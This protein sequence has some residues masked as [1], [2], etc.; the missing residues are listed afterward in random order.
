MMIANDLQ[1][2]LGTDGAAQ[3]CGGAEATQP[4]PGPSIPLTLATPAE[5]VRM[6]S[7]STVDDLW[8]SAAGERVK[9]RE[10]GSL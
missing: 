5:G 2:D 7:R 1:S 8:V 9:H 4:L 10:V 3:C 6:H